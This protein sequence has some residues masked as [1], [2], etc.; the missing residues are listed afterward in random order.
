[1]NSLL[2]SYKQAV[3]RHAMLGDLL[4]LQVLMEGI[5]HVRHHSQNDKVK[6]MC[7]LLSKLKVLLVRQKCMKLRVIQGRCGTLLPDTEGTYVSIWSSPMPGHMIDDEN[8]SILSGL[9]IGLNVI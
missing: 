3:L 1:M 6:K 4:I 5:V 8:L 9:K 7:V 2:Y